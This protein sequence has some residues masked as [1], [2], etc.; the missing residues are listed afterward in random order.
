MAQSKVQAIDEFLRREDNCYVLPD[1]R[2]YR[3]D[4][5][6]PIVALVD[7]L[8]NLHRKFVVETTITLSFSTFCK[9]RDKTTVKTSCFLKRS[10]CLCKTHA[11]MKMMIEAI[12]AL[13]TRHLSW[14]N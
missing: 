6:K 14:S 2:F 3:K 10:V 7:S 9:G 13:P 12:P 11:N 4:K 5:G 1:K 8:R